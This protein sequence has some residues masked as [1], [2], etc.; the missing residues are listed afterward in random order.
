VGPTATTADQLLVTW[1]L[2]SL[3]LDW[4][5]PLFTCI[6]LTITVGYGFHFQHWHSKTLPIQSFAQDSGRTLVHAGYGYLKGS[7]NTNS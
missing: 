6:Y 4:C 2:R 3:N 7:P 5:G 1:N